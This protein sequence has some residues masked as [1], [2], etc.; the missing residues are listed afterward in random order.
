MSN[1]VYCC[2]KCSLANLEAQRDAA[3]SY[4][5][6]S[7]VESQIRNVSAFPSPCS[8]CQRINCPHGLDHN[9]ACTAK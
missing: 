3:T 4:K 9:N 7:L 6:R 1:S 2:K 8:L 5:D